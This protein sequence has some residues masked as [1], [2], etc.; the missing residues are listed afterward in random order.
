VRA[1]AQE[2]ATKAFLDPAIPALFGTAAVSIR[3][4]EIPTLM[5]SIAQ[6]AVATTAREV[7]D[8]WPLEVAG[9]ERVMHFRLVRPLRLGGMG[10]VFLAWDERLDRHVVLKRLAPQQEPEEG[11]RRLEREAR[12]AAR[13]RHPYIVTIYSLEYVGP[14]PV[15]VQ[16]YVDGDDLDARVGALPG[17]TALSLGKAIANALAYAHDKGIIHRDL[18]PRNVRIRPDGT[19][20]VLDFGLGKVFTATSHERTEPAL[21]KAGTVMGTP[22]Y[23][24]PEQWSADEVTPA[25]DVFAFGVLLFEMIAGGVP[26]D[27]ATREALYGNILR[28]DPPVDTL[29]VTKPIRQLIRACLATTPT[30]RPTMHDVETILERALAP[31]TNQGAMPDNEPVDTNNLVVPAAHEPSAWI[32]AQRQRAKN[33]ITSDDVIMEV[34]VAL[35]DITTVLR[36]PQL[37]HV[38]KDLAAFH[39]R[40]GRFDGK[41]R[42]GHDDVAGAIRS[43]GERFYRAARIDGTLYYAISAP[44][45]RNGFVPIEFVLDEVLHLLAYSSRFA[46]MITGG[47]EASRLRISVALTGQAVMLGSAEW[48]DAFG[49]TLHGLR[50]KRSL[51]LQGAVIV[52]LPYLQ[53]HVELAA[54]VLCDQLVAGAEFVTVSPE[55]YVERAAELGIGHPKGS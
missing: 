2:F 22:H 7:S 46:A 44:R 55:R 40:I 43:N 29:N 4:G 3:R 13:L 37:K 47:G 15:L 21:T 16:E 48:S 45:P 36:L 25:A 34:S 39:Q 54:Q 17:N 27:G 20:S 50:T 30:D 28:G 23:M 14:E 52:A 26:F 31:T 10:S 41:V 42:T 49:A 6:D 8:V 11:R 51:A 35:Q 53:E 19:P 1:A 12:A 18:K 32:T 38:L 33:T 5:R 24:A 9:G